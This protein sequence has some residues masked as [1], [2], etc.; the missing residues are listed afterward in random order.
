M[1]DFSNLVRMYDKSGVTYFEFNDGDVLKIIP[2]FTDVEGFLLQRY[3]H[4]ENSSG[5]WSEV[6]KGNL[7]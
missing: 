3:F 2:E 6:H 7:R 1:F 5:R 4:F